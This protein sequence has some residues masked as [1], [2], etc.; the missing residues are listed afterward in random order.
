MKNNLLKSLFLLT[1]TSVVLTSCVGEDD[2]VIPTVKTPF[3]SEEFQDIQHNTVLDLT[4]WTNFA[5]AG[6]ILAWHIWAGPFV[7]L[8]VARSNW[9]MAENFTRF[10]FLTTSLGAIVNILLNFLLIPPYQGVGAAIA[11]IIAYAVASHISC[12][13]YPP[14]FKPGLMLTKALFIPFRFQQN[15]NYFNKIKQILI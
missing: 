8:G 14:M 13:L 7:F 15:L 6:T 10:S 3:Y 9:L 1:T 4:G 12:L 2:Y 5:E 11:T